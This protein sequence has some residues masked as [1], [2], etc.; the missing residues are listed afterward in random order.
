MKKPAK[1]KPVIWW[2]IK[3]PYGG[4]GAIHPSYFAHTRSHAIRQIEYNVSR[5]WADLRKQGHTVVKVHIR[6]VARRRK[7]P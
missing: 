3:S 6:E 5:S 4:G 2:G 1:S 7:K